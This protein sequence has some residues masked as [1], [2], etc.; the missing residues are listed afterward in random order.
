[1]TS[2]TSSV[3]TTASIRSR[4]EKA[5]DRY[6]CRPLPHREIFVFVPTFLS[7]LFVIRF[8]LFLSYPPLLLFVDIKP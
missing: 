5:A 4:E 8:S 2:S 7:L 6:D 3:T 1:M